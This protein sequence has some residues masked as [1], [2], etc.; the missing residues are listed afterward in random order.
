[1]PKIKQWSDEERERALQWVE[2]KAKTGTVFRGQSGT[3]DSE[4]AALASLADP[5]AVA[6]RL[7]DSLTAEAWKRLLSALRQR[8]HAEK[9]A[10]KESAPTPAPREKKADASK[11]AIR[12]FQDAINAVDVALRG[13]V[14]SGAV[15]TMRNEAIADAA[16]GFNF[17]GPHH[18]TSIDVSGRVLRITCPPVI[19]ENQPTMDDGDIHIRE[20]AVQMRIEIE[21][22]KDVM[23]H[24]GSAGLIDSQPE[25]DTWE[26][27]AARILA[28]VEKSGR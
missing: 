7:R 8:K 1:M 2:R 12:K 28:Y 22:V 11:A 26:N 3:V 15:L 18:G 6:D 20:G 4:I 19:S 23:R 24:N 10:E 21:P 17:F 25:A 27:C 5:Q 13:L 16:R 14:K 9:H